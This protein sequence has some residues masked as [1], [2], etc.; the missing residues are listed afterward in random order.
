MMSTLK[1][2]LRTGNSTEVLRDFKRLLGC[3]GG[4]ALGSGYTVLEKTSIQNFRN[5]REQKTELRRF[6]D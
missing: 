2:E 1:Y 6:T 5:G 3:F 4:D